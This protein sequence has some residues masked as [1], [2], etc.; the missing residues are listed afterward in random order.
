MENEGYFAVQSFGHADVLIVKQAI[1]Y[2]KVGRDVAV[3]AE[4]TDVLVLMM[5]HWKTSMG[6]MVIAMGEE[7]KEEEGI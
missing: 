3:M 7:A 6:N 5:S 1:D 2:A 4:D